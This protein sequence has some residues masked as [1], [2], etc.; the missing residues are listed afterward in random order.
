MLSIKRLLSGAFIVA[1]MSATPAFAQT[2]AMPQ[3]QQ[4][5][6]DV[7]VSDDELSK[8][9][10]AYKQVQVLGQ[11]AQQEMATAVQDEGMDIERFNEIHQASMNPQQESDATSDEMEKHGKVV[12]KLDKMQGDFQSKLQKA[13]ENQDMDMERF[14]QISM[15][16]QSDTE[17]QQRLQEMM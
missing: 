10:N 7:D 14:E 1:A 17:L 15:A 5:Q 11:Q 13:V 8:F 16:L 9:A 12:E 4:Q 3:Q 6:V 2:Q